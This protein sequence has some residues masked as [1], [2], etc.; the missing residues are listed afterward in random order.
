MKPRG[1]SLVEVI[2][3]TALLLLVLGNATTFVAQHVS[4]QRRDHTRRSN[5]DTQLLAMQQARSN[6]SVVPSGVTQ[7]TVQSGLVE[8]KDGTL[9]TWVYQK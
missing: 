5:F 1:F 8:L 7:T 3:A 2:L 4:W 9:K 6:L